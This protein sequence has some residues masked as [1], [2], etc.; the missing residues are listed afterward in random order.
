MS[1]TEISLRLLKKFKM[2]PY[3]S[4]PS[5]VFVSRLRSNFWHS[6]AANNSSDE[7]YHRPNGNNAYVRE[8]LKFAQYGKDRQGRT[9]AEIRPSLMPNS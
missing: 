6:A 3:S 5:T 9:M 7:G 4:R 1:F 2:F 8:K